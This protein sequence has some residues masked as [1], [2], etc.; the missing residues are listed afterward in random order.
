MPRHCR[1]AFVSP[2]DSGA[3]LHTGAFRGERIYSPR[4][5]CHGWCYAKARAFG[6]SFYP[7]ASRLRL[8]GAR[9]NVYADARY[10]RAQERRIFA[11]F[12]PM[13]CALPDS[14]SDIIRVLSEKSRAY[15][16]FA[17]SCGDICFRAL[18]SAFLGKGGTAPDVVYELPR[19]RMPNGRNVFRSVKSKILQFATRSGSIVFLSSALIYILCSLDTHFRYTASAGES[20]LCAISGF[21][22]FILK[23][24]GLDDYRISAAL[25]SGFLPRKALFPR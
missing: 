9:D 19:F 23:P 25:I 16:F 1:R 21:G 13:Q 22:S 18:V 14:Y 3:F 8:H 2:A 6:K 12:Y 15:R 10:L 11:C 7:R 5:F 20:L 4:L 24:L 17:L